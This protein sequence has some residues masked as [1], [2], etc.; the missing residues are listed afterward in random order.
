MRRISRF[1]SLLL[2]LCMLASI[3]P[4]EVMAVQTEKTENVS[5]WQE[6][7]AAL[8]DE[9]VTVISMNGEIKYQRGEFNG[10]D[11]LM[12]ERDV[13][14]QGNGNL[15]SLDC[16]GIILGGNVTF[17]NIVISFNNSVRNAVV[18]NGYTLTLDGVT[19]Y[20]G[21]RQLV[22]LFCGEITDYNG[23]NKVPASG[24]NGKI[25]IRGANEL[26]EIYAGSLSDGAT[27]STANQNDFS[28]TSTIVV[29]SSTTGTIGAVYAHGAR[30]PR[31]EGEGNALIGDPSKYTVSGQ[32]NIILNSNLVKTVDGNTGGS[33]GAAL[34]YNYSADE[35]LQYGL[36][37]TNL[38]SL[39]LEDGHLQPK[40]GSSFTDGASLTIGEKGILDLQ[41]YDDLTVGDFSGGGKLVLG[42]EQIL[43]I[44]GRITGATEA[45]IGSVYANQQSMP[46]KGHAYIRIF[47]G[48]IP[49]GSEFVFTE[50]PNYA[51]LTP[52]YD[53]SGGCW[54]VPSD[55]DSTDEI[56]ISDITIGSS[57]LATVNETELI[58]PIESTY[59]TRP[60]QWGALELVPLKVWVNGTQAVQEASD[61]NGYAYRT[62]SLL[63]S[64]QPDDED[65]SKDVIWIES[66]GGIFDPL[67]EGEYDILIQIPG[68]YMEDKANKELR[69]SVTISG[70]GQGEEKNTPVAVP[71][72]KNGLT[73]NGNEQIG[74]PEGTGYSL[75]NHKK[76]DAG[77]YEA[78]AVLESG[79]EWSTGST[80]SLRI[81]WKIAKAAGKG[82]VT[83][84]DWTYGEEVNKPIL[85]SS[86]HSTQTGI[87][88]EYKRIEEEDAA[89]K[90]FIPGKTI[91]SGEY[92]LRATFA[93]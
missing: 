87:I 69:F 89:F 32:V 12:I 17:E 88:Y 35:Y 8:E 10:D 55:P 15:L 3:V 83:L 57:F 72:A 82:S 45:Y 64:P 53:S 41:K 40:S 75:S 60:N 68:A 71:I 59:S 33:A 42:Q 27:E 13:T 61:Y 56:I 24:G 1:L 91:E 16:G 74:V 62:D 25:I 86:T 29:E 11:A 14:I 50:N 6:F 63:I 49:S 65:Y 48:S 77:E 5:S 39:I 20:S 43:A 34:T 54:R 67:P 70:D 21:T 73:Y 46:K 9:T 76:M 26:G 92:T 18:A 47:N 81:A 36:T 44:T 22:H 30:E 19:K 28:G 38:S 58:I 84:K 66:S 4:M 51:A 78:V 37:F 93:E 23:T 79:Y 52:V 90:P 7:K 2:S 31:G 80:A 85:Q